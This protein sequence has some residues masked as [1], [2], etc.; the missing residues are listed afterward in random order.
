MPSTI[1]QELLTATKLKTKKKEERQEFLHR[2]TDAVQDLDD[3][4][5]KGLSTEAQ[6][7]VN[8][9]AAAVKTDGEDATIEEFPDLEDEEE[10][11]Q[12]EESP[13]ADEEGT[14]EEDEE[15]SETE[16]PEEESDVA[17]TKTTKKAPPKKKA[18]EKP[19]AKAA[20]PEK[21]TPAKP[22][23]KKA[24]AGPKATG[25]KVLIKKI[26]FKNPTIS[27]DDL[28]EKLGKDGTKPSK[29]TVS[30]IRSE[31]RHSLFV[32]RDLGALKSE[33]DLG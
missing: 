30:A 27:V 7:W 33:L 25:I 18:A 9:G 15:E 16:E 13:E 3:D 20:K 14:E 22:A 4:D 29:L 10:G 11:A 1:E 5:W 6:K 24:A 21:K 8:A 19:A 26:V 12:E 31:F 17:E 28:I 2:L 32:L 23:E